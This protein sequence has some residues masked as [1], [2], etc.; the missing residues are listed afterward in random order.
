M[1][2]ESP[3]GAS[4]LTDVALSATHNYRA[5]FQFSQL[6]GQSMPIGSRV[7]SDGKRRVLNAA[8]IHDD[9]FATTHCESKF[10]VLQEY[11]RGMQRDVVDFATTRSVATGC[12]WS[13]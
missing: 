5:F 7:L 10:P 1:A 9:A 12:D 4:T 3:V 6:M 11:L 8:R 13:R 2:I